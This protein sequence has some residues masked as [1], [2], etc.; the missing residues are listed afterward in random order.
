MCETAAEC[1]AHADRVM[2]DMARDI[3][4]QFAERIIDDGFVKRGMAHAGADGQRLSVTRNLVEA[5]DLVNIDEMGGLGEAER[6]ARDE[7]LSARQ[8]TAVLRRD[9]GQNLQRLVERARHVADE[10]R[11]LHA[12]DGP[13]WDG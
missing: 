3:G 11:W 10:W 9:F 2:R 13:A 5:G 6:H 8:H 4:E 12:A 1:A 7:T